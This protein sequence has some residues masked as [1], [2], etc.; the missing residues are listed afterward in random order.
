M[1]K[2][3][4]LITALTFTVSILP[5]NALA[6]DSDKKKGKKK[7]IKVA[8]PIP[9][10]TVNQRQTEL[11]NR[12]KKVAK[13]MADNSMMILMSADSKIY[14]NDV[15][16][17]YRQENN[18]YYL[19]SLKQKG[20]TL[21]ITK[22]GGNVQETLF[23]PK[24]NPRAE[25]WNGRMYSNADATEISGVSNIVDAKELK[26]F[27]TAVKSKGAFT[28]SDGN[29]SLGSSAN[30]YVIQGNPREYGKRE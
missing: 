26:A 1:K 27:M 20:V 23:L 22:N 10:F 2:I 29:F 24:R 14:S 13:A 19:T 7:V 17:Y 11:A 9:K 25:T 5:T 15:D 3:L 8:P 4:L 30:L 12:R 6:K 28:S 21:V 16:F 18:L